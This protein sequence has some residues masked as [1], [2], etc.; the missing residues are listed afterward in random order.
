MTNWETRGEME[1]RGYIFI[2]FIGCVLQRLQR[3]SKTLTGNQREGE[4]MGSQNRVVVSKKIIKVLVSHNFKFYNMKI[5]PLPPP[6][7]IRNGSIL[8]EVDTV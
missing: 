2:F 4:R 6:P 3:E 5:R 1:T 7:P 8:T